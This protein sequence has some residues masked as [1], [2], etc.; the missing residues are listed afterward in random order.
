[1][2]APLPPTEVDDVWVNASLSSACDI[3]A[4]RAQYLRRKQKVTLLRDWPKD[5]G[6]LWIISDQHGMKVM[7]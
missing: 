5:Q 4:G 2:V 7:Y 1:M 3:A 6:P